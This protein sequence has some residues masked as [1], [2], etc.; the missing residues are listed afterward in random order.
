[1]PTPS[2]RSPR[3]LLALASL[4]MLVGLAGCDRG[5][6]P[7]ASAAPPAGPAAGA[8]PA[9][10]T[11]RLDS[12]L[13]AR[14]GIQTAKAGDPT[15]LAGVHVPGS[16]EYD[17]DAYAEVG[18]RLDG[19]VASVH[20]RLG[21]RVEKGDLLA[22][23]VVPSLADTQAAV[24]VAQ[25]AL[26]AAQKNA[27]REHDLFDRQLT[28]AREVEVADAELSRVQAEHAAASTR[29]VAVGVDPAATRGALRLTA[30][31]AGVVVQRSATLGAFLSST[32]NAFVVADTARLVA[33]LDA[34]EA[35]LPYLAIGAEVKFRADGVPD[36]VFTGKL[37]HLDPSIGKNSR[38]L[39]ARVEVPNADGALR[40]G[41][42]VRAAITV[43]SRPGSGLVLSSDAVQPLGS[44]DVA[45]VSKGG[46]VYEMRVLRI[47]RRTAEIVEVESG[48]VAG[49]SV[50]VEGAFVLRAEAAKQ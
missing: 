8:E 45:F 16:L 49:E 50:V 15:A 14:F 30:P 48:V 21:D 31:I 43:T 22:A 36:R 34:H 9:V 28:T 3:G 4:A 5:L 41:M 27:K 46:G 44:E 25:S 20:A 12:T 47:K 2:T 32:G 24:L 38:L 13:E 17:P 37:S 6:V 26:H 35:D 40:S 42:F 1:M 23:L 7:P 33:V 11:V 39:R 18:P 19:R 29:L 10:R